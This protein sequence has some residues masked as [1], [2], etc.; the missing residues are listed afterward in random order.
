MTDSKQ[1]D[2]NEKENIIADQ[3]VKRILNEDKKV[4]TTYNTTVGHGYPG[5]TTVPISEADL[6]FVKMILRTAAREAIHLYK[7]AKERGHI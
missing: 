7:H 3:V 4:A 6:P 5:D 2:L 1:D